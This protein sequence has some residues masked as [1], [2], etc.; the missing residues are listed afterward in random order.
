MIDEINSI[1]VS[2]RG[3]CKDVPVAVSSTRLNCCKWRKTNVELTSWLHLFSSLKIIFFCG[4]GTVVQRLPWSP[5][6]PHGNPMIGCVLLSCA[7]FVCYLWLLWFPPTVQTRQ[8]T[9]QRK[10]VWGTRVCSGIDCWH[11]QGCSPHARGDHWDG[12]QHH[13]GPQIL[14]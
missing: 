8:L 10:C 11:V 2:D 14:Y 1:T 12:L 4:F 9:S 6:S 7:E 13:H 5:W 3:G